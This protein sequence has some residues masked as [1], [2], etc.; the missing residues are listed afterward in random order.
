LVALI[1]TF[2]TETP[3]SHPNYQKTW[4]LA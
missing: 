4:I 3:A 1:I 2:E